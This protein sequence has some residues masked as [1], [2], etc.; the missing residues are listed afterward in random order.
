[1][2]FEYYDT[3]DT[4]QYLYYDDQDHFILADFSKADG[5][6]E[7][8]DDPGD[9]WNNPPISEFNMKTLEHVH[10][11]YY[12]T[13]DDFNNNKPVDAETFA[14]ALGINVAELKK[15]TKDLDAWDKFADNWIDD[16]SR[17]YDPDWL[18]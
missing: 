14:K 1:M 18:Y 5:D 3:I 9:N 12:L 7:Y 4:Y 16:R 6:V 8:I 17:D 11:Y 15:I 2:R 10:F 13:E